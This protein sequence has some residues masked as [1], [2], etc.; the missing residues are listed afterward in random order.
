VCQRHKRAVNDLGFAS[1]FCRNGQFSHLNSDMVPSKGKVVH[2]KKKFTPLY[3]KSA[4]EF[5]QKLWIEIHSYKTK[6][7]KNTLN[8]QNGRLQP[9]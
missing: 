3:G 7:V 6:C 1:A 8:A 4:V 9:V 2:L 5:R